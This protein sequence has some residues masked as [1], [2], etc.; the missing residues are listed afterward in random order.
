MQLLQTGHFASLTY[1]F[2]SLGQPP[3][4]SPIILTCCLI[5]FQAL[6]LVMI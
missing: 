4:L 6:L 2:F 3:Y 1:I 5:K